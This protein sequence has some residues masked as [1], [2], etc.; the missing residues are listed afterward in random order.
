MKNEKFCFSKG[1]GLIA[2][3]G[4]LLV[5]FVLFTQAA[6]QPTS[7]SSR[8][9]AVL[10][11]T[12]C[13]TINDG[14]GGRLFYT[15]VSA[16]KVQ[17]F[18]DDAGKYEIVE[19]VGKYCKLDVATSTVCRNV[20][21]ENANCKKMLF[22][23]GDVDEF[24]TNASC[25]GKILKADG[26]VATAVD[27]QTASVGYCVSSWSAVTQL[28]FAC[29]APRGAI[30]FFYSNGK[31]YKDAAMKYDVTSYGVGNMCKLANSESVSLSST[32][33][34]V[35][36]DKQVAN[37]K[38]NKTIYSDL[39]DSTKI[40][41][42]ASGVYK[43]TDAYCLSSLAKDAY[44][45]AN[46]ADVVC[47]KYVSK[48]DATALLRYAGGNKYYS[49]TGGTVAL[50]LLTPQDVCRKTVRESSCY[51]YAL[52]A[53]K[54]ATNMN[55]KFKTSNEIT[56][57]ESDGTTSIADLNTYCVFKNGDDSAYTMEFN[58]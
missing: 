33:V 38:V 32:L 44:L 7:S 58:N 2:L 22:Q 43:T 47:A 9:S 52:A 45:S 57:F 27:L 39:T 24:Y 48:G 51:N 49:G 10:P 3:V 55:K 30:N 28:Q 12:D 50:R 42:D 53:G 6:N 18:K 25:L 13:A 35:T 34:P 1:T 20:Q 5:G 37:G 40:Y 56:F 16:G 15:K 11:S 46:P 8:A 21:M 31:Y 14:V 29:P 36:C 4:V 17:Y 41:Y 19:G 26:A 54:K 23:K